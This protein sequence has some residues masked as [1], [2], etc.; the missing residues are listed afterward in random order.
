MNFFFNYLPKENWNAMKMS[1]EN[2]SPTDKVCATDP[3]LNSSGVLRDPVFTAYKFMLMLFFG[4]QHKQGV[5][6]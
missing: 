1:R 6:K 3:K 4:K 2:S 5:K